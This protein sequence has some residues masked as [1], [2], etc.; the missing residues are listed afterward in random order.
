MSKMLR[1]V[2]VNNHEMCGEIFAPVREYHYSRE[3]I[4]NCP[5]LAR[6]LE[7]IYALDDWKTGKVYPFFNWDFD[8]VRVLL[9]S[10]KG[11]VWVKYKTMRQNEEIRAVCTHLDNDLKEAIYLFDVVHEHTLEGEC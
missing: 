10:A 9:Y 2:N 7:R 6:E 3:V 5:V 4:Q 1:S 8:E 11:S